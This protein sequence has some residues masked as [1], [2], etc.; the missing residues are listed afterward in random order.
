MLI[1][2]I[3]KNSD[4]FTYNGLNIMKTIRFFVELAYKFGFIDLK[5]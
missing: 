5:N 1:I 3:R 2:E 4:G